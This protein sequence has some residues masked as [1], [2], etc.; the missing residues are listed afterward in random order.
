M[1]KA[2]VI[3]S[4]LNQFNDQIKEEKE[5][6]TKPLNEA[7]KAERGRWKPLEAMYEDAIE[8]LRGKMSAYQTAVEKERR[9]KEM[10]IASRIKEG[11]GN[12]SLETAVKK[13]DSL[14][15]VEKEVA[16]DAGLVQF[17]EVQKLK[18]MDEMLIPREYLVIDEKRVLE[19]LKAGR[20]V[21]GAVVETVQVPV[22]YR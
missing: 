22:N 21:A 9:E 14:E 6:V 15:K 5:K 3:L 16:T 20:E 12:L 11:R 2:V 13:I 8:G 18:I 19:A 17:R 10:A 7:L 1:S 4:K